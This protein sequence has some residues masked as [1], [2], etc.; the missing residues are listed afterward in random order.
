MWHLNNFEI[1][2]FLNR[3]ILII[4]RIDEI[5]KNER[6]AK[7]V[8][9]FF[10]ELKNL[11]TSKVNL[12][13]LIENKKNLSKISSKS[14][15]ASLESSNDHQQPQSPKSPMFTSLPFRY[16]FATDGYCNNN[17]GSFSHQNSTSSTSDSITTLNNLNVD[18]QH[19]TSL[20]SESRVNFDRMVESEVEHYEEPVKI[21][22]VAFSLK[23]DEQKATESNASLA[24]LKAKRIFFAQKKLD[25]EA[26][27]EENDTFVETPD[28]SKSTLETKNTEEANSSSRIVN[29][30]LPPRLPDE[31]VSLKKYGIRRHHSAPQSD[32]K[33]LQVRSS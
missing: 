28:Y 16:A 27:R 22:L 18:S 1:Q 4:A 19:F 8:K 32:A 3:V 2:F 14:Y 13:Q 11:M 26:P 25:A 30:T 21:N 29:Q 6:K 7:K 12:S 17:F 15:V 9:R 31:V 24:N 20:I 10:R 5:N 33:W 23:S